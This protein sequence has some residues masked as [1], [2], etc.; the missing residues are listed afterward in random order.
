MATPYGS[1]D[2]GFFL[3]GGRDVLSSVSNIDVEREA[4]VKPTTA[5]GVQFPTFQATGQKSAR[6]TQTGFFDP[7]IGASNEA[8]CEKENTSHVV[9]LAHQG[10]TAGRKMIGAVGAFAG[11]YK[12]GVASEDLHKATA[13]YTV[14]GDV[15]DPVLVATLAARGTAGST[16]AG[17]VDNAVL[18]SNGGAGYCAVQS[19][20][21][22][23]YTNIIV[24][25]RH[26]VN[27]STF[28]DLMAF[29]AVTTSPIAERK[30]V[31]GTV[32]RYLAMSWAWTGAGSGQSAT[33]AVGFARA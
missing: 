26:S 1:K 13:E 22:G 25:V 23:G 11:K 16:E 4:V 24:T 20:T 12:R 27:N 3:V 2:V 30:T 32:N 10:N 14:S 29:T 18:T 28:A 19:L 21:L 9:L 31:A 8:I 6:I 15:E 33:F 17:S 5:L 7:A